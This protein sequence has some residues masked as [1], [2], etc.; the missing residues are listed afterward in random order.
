MH[1][2]LVSVGEVPRF[3]LPSLTSGNE[4]MPTLPTI[5][6]AGFSDAGDASDAA[7]DDGM[8][9]TEAELAAILIPAICNRRR[10]ECMCTEYPSRFAPE[11]ERI[12]A[13]TCEQDTLRDYR[14]WWRNNINGP[15]VVVGEPELSEALNR[16]SS[17]NGGRHYISDFLLADARAGEHCTSVFECADGSQCLNGVCVRHQQLGEPCLTEL[18]IWRQRALPEASFRC[19]SDFVCEEGRCQAPYRFA[20]PRCGAGKLERYRAE[21]LDCIPMGIPCNSFSDCG[22]GY[23]AGAGGIEMRCVPPGGDDDPGDHA[24]Y[25]CNG[26]PCRRGHVCLHQTS[27]PDVCVQVVGEGDR[28]DGAWCGRDTHCEAVVPG[29]GQCIARSCL[30]SHTFGRIRERVV[31]PED[32]S[33]AEAM[34]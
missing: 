22:P 11:E 4:P 10:N 18:E 31:E 6:D 20:Q 13:T 15:V 19:D 34:P 33:D 21:H 16:L 25:E 27:R 28:C 2:A 3:H 29:G 8:H 14:L 26:A 5:T 32:T 17:C 24:M 9:G 30:T 1:G 7:I 12:G 23:C